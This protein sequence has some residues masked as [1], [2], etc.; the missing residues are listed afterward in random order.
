MANPAPKRNY[1]SPLERWKQYWPVSS[2]PPA[3]DLS[4]ITPELVRKRI[5]Y[6][7]RETRRLEA[8][9]AEARR[10]RVEALVLLHGNRYV[11]KAVVARDLGI[12]VQRIDEI[13][14]EN[15]KYRHRPVPKRPPRDQ[16][17]RIPR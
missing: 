15:R 13:L 9:L 17:P 1:R 8:E 2:G 6:W 10:Q 14:Y 4:F 12:S 11:S 3:L 16:R 5:I 7:H